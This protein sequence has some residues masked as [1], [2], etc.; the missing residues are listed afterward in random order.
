MNPT[1]T[2]P[3]PSVLLTGFSPFGGETINP[4]WQAVSALDGEKI[5]GHR[6][7]ARRLPVEFGT[8]L[9]ALRDAILESSPSL[10]LCVGQA[11]GRAQLSLERV[12]INVDDARM[13]DNAGT[14]PID[15][16]V[17]DGGPAAYFAT[18][19]IKAMLRALNAAGIPAQ[20]SQTAG[21]YVCNHVFYGL[22]H[23][24]ERT[25]LARGGFLHVPFSPEQAARHVDAASLPIDTLISAL[26]ILLQ[27]ALTTGAD[28][29]LAAGSEH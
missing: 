24:L 3:S 14:R 5:S 17:V 1:S 16:P 28:I 8:S 2:L 6:I 20:I 18:L 27:T 29:R 25:P 19:P 21:T 12:A 13:P 9:S 4:S 23:A 7:I 26:R 11:G 15:R 22:M 10:V